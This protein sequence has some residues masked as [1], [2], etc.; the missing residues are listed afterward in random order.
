[1]GW[2]ELTNSKLPEESIILGWQRYRKA[3]YQATEL[4]KPY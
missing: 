4:A 2:D 1:M 3:A